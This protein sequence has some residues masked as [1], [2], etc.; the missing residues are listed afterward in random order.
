[1]RLLVSCHQ[2]KLRYDATGRR[3]GQRFRCRCGEVVTIQQPKGHDAAV[4]HCSTCG[5]AREQGGKACGYC[6]SDFTIHETDLDTICPGCLARVSDRA[7]YCHHCATPLAADVVAS[8]ASRLECPVCPGRKLYSRRLSDAAVTVL[9]CRVC[10]GMWIG[11]EAFHDLLNAEERRT[12]RLTV[13]HRPAAA[14]RQGGYRK[15]PGCSGMMVRRNLG[16]GKS[17]IVL[18]VCGEHGLWFDCDE[19]SHALAWI[20]AGGLEDARLC[21]ARLKRSPDVHRKRQ[22]NESTAENRPEGRSAAE[23]LLVEAGQRGVAVNWSIMA[24]AL[25]AI[26][27]RSLGD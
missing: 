27:D 10:A 26:F 24:E 17:G 23:G 13:T 12:V 14:G 2:C 15:C 4:V 8:E 22:R 7:R 6:G 25:A 5:A 21:V 19:L 16:R 20:R 9:E 3:V 11:L 18:D 1:M